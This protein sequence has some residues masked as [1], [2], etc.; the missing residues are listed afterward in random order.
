MRTMRRIAGIVLLFFAVIADA[1]PDFVPIVTARKQSIGDTVVV[2]GLVTV[3]SGRF[4]SSSGDEGFA[5]QDQTA[6]IWISTNKNLRLGLGQQV[7]VRGVLSRNAGKLQIV[8]SESAVTSLPG[9]ELRVPTGAVGESTLGY[10]VTIEG[11]IHRVTRD[12]QYGHKV[13]VDDG[14]GAVQVFLNASTD[15]DVA[16]FRTGRTV[17]VTGFA[18]QYETTY[19]IEPRSANDIRH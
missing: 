11:T 1:V 8:A 13:F 6:G 18:S 17:R 2:R 9:R 5:I 12:D 16:R 3:P 4:R 14:S 10:L 19:E 7:R 15:I